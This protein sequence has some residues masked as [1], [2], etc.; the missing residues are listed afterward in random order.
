MSGGPLLDIQDNGGGSVSIAW[1][2][3]TA[4][5]PTSYNV[6]VNKVLNQN[7]PSRAATITGLQCASYARAA[8]APTPNNSARPQSMPPVGLVTDALTYE[9]HVAAIIGGV[10]VARTIGQN[11]TPGP[12][13][14][15]LTTPMK[16]PSPFPLTGQTEIS[17]Q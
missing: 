11:V 16:R 10:E 15:M 4:A 2:Q 13:S 9:I 3:F 8:V 7:V 14:V 12:T 5:A 6:Y 17:W 1:P